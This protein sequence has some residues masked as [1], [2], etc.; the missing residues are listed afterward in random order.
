MAQLRPP[1]RWPLAA[2]LAMALAG[3]GGSGGGGGSSPTSTPPN[4]APAPGQVTIS[5][6]VTYDFVPHG[7]GGGL[8]YGQTESRPVRLATVQFIDGGNVLASTRTDLSGNYSLFVDPDQMGFVRVRAESV[9]LGIPSWDYRVV[10]NTSADAIYTLDGAVASSGTADSTRDL[11][12]ASGWTGTGYGEPRA[13]APFAILDTIHE[14]VE[15]LVAADPTIALPEL[16]IHWSTDNVAAYGSDGNPDPATGDI[17]TSSYLVNKPLGLNGIYLLGKEDDDT[18][19]YDRHVVLHEFGHY[20]E[21]QLGRSDNIGGPH[22]FGELLDMR[23]AFSEGWATAWAALALDDPNYRDA[24]GPRQQFAFAFSVESGSNSAPGWYSERSILGLIY[25]LVD[26]A[27]DGNDV[28]SYPFAD[29]WSVMTGAI[30]A[31]PAMTSVFPFLNAIKTAHPGDAVLLD[32]RAAADDIAWVMDDFGDGEVND[33]GSADVLPIYTRATINDANGVDLCSTDEFKGAT[34][35]SVNKLSS[36]R[37]IRFTPNFPGSVTITMTATS[38]PAGEY[39]DPDFRV[40]RQGALVG[41][42]L[43][44][45]STACMDTS[46]PGWM[47]SDCVE[48]TSMPLQAQEHVLEIEEWTNTNDSNDPKYPPIGRTC[49]NVTV[50]QP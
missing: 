35:G 3:C 4:P 28:F 10:D 36:R 32:Q 2:L 17:G 13:A 9:E 49:F 12:A 11:H 22:A 19:E 39:A 16:S 45:P 34:T 37:F 25:D 1:A 26:T 27:I 44:Q 5:G 47:E 24:S 14:A 48:S 31:T 20:L 38:I 29:V 18:D 8:D 42:S 50:M 23:V 15:F 33:A 21:A 41:K 7:I 30:R 46:A 6:Q 40:H 43:D